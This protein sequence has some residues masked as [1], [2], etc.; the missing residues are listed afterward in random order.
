MLARQCYAVIN[1]AA[2]IRYRRVLF[3]LNLSSAVVGVKSDGL[4]HLQVCKEPLKNF[5]PD[6][7]PSVFKDYFLQSWGLP[8]SL[9]NPVEKGRDPQ[10][11][12]F[13][14]EKKAGRAG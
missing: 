1:G 10:S 5:G 9:F 3:A 11:Y 6:L 4:V 12:T 13:P 7:R 2:M 14:F 8:R